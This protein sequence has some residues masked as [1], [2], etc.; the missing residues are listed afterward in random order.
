MII[1]IL[2]L[3]LGAMFAL[4]FTIYFLDNPAERTSYVAKYPYIL[5]L[6]PGQIAPHGSV[7]IAISSLSNNL[8][9]SI[10]SA[11]VISPNGQV[12]KNDTVPSSNSLIYPQNFQPAKSDILGNYTVVITLKNETLLISGSFRTLSSPF[13]SSFTN[14]IFGAGLGIT[15][16]VIG[17]IVTLVYQI[18]SQNNQDRSRRLDDKAKWMIDNTKYYMA[19]LADSSSICSAFKPQRKLNPTYKA[20]NVHNILFYT[21]KFYEDYQEFR[22]NCGFY[23]F[24]D[25]VTED[26][27]AKV[28]DKIFNFMDEMTNDYS[29]LRQFFGLKTQLEFMNQKNY[30]M[31]LDRL[32][33]WLHDAKKSREYFLTHFTYRWVLLISINRALMITYSSTSKIAKS[34]ELIVGTDKDILD[35]H[36]H[37]LNQEF[38]GKEKELYYLLFPPKKK[39][40]IGLKKL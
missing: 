30:K 11:K 16:G 8:N 2:S 12:F 10:L 35:A 38:Y 32:T 26:F 31:Y 36:I 5:S 20:V 15:I 9:N 19:L 33:L 21:I 3:A 4:L 14:F 28:E 18:V 25:Y 27:L 40:R 23:Y 37:T 39:L 22:K 29:Q 6:S 7:N 24:D 13:L 17:T 1:W 34:L